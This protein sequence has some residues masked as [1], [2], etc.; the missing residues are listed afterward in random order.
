MPLL[1]FIPPA[2]AASVLVAPAAYAVPATY[3]QRVAAGARVQVVTVDLKDPHTA[4]DIGLAHAAP[5]ANTAQE[6]FGDEPFG[7]M[8]Q[9]AHAAAV[10]NG[11]FFSKDAEKR[12]MGNMVRGG[13]IVKYS[14]WEDA[15]TTFALLPG[16]HPIMVTARAE[17]KP[18]WQSHW[19]SI[20]CGPRL[21]FNG[22]SWLHPAEEGFSDSHVLGVAGR[23]ALG[24]SRDGRWLY[25]VSFDSGVSLAQEARVMKALGAWEAMNLDGGA[26]RALAIQG[27]TVVSPG[28][29]LTNVLAVYDSRV[30]APQAIKRFA[31]GFQ[32]ATA[33]SLTEADRGAAPGDRFI[34]RL[35]PGARLPYAK[36]S[37][38]HVFR[39][40]IVGIRQ[41]ALAFSDQSY[42]EIFAAQAGRP[43]AF[44]LEFKAKLV[45]EFM[46]VYFDGR[47]DGDR[48]AGGSFEVRSTE[49]AGLY[50][51]QDG[52]L[53]RLNQ[54]LSIDTDWHRYRIEARPEWVKIY[55]DDNPWPVVE[56]PRGTPGTGLGL[57]GR[58]MFT[59]FQLTDLTQPAARPTP[60]R[61]ATRPTEA[62]HPAKP[63]SKLE[64]LG[65]TIQGLL[66]QIFSP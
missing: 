36:L 34:E 50:L 66:Q 52:E 60:Q 9:R 56:G 25:L 4:L 59:G 47:K 65:D 48:L 37:F 3:T 55:L 12:V 61:P 35:K 6:T 5:R 8:V 21:L 10:I 2:L 53:V 58:G 20:T 14:Q 54:R 64:Q 49:P 38:E 22:Q 31:A 7:P 40:P 39:D 51:R 63:K 1:R 15:G 42:G 29:D 13:Q 23:S 45:D 44:R 30:P 46:R 11:T 62:P 41:G 28:R 19:L 17:G 57:S 27:R 16:N 43:Q 18:D 24:Y 32:G 33:A 26:S